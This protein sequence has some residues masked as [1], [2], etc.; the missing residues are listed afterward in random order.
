[1]K[2]GADTSEEYSLKL[3]DKDPLSSFRE[4]F[5]IPE[6]TVYL[7]GNSLGLL[8]KRAEES[9]MKVKEEWKELGI[10]GWT[11]GETPWFFMA[12]TLGE[13]AA[14][15]VGAEPK[16][17]V[18]TGTTTVNIH[19]LVSTLY[20]PDGKKDKIL[21][22][23]LNFPTDIYA[24]EGL[25]ELKGLDPEKKLK[26][27][28]SSDGDTLDED[29]IVDM[30]TDDIALIHLPS[31]LYRSGQLLDMQY[32]T[33]KAH[34]RDIVIGFDCSH[35]AGVIPHDLHDLGVDYAMWCGYKYLNGGPGCSAFLY[36]N[37]RHFEDE[38]KLKGWFGYEKEKQFDL[39]LDFVHEKSAGGWQISS[40]AILSSAPLLGS[41]EIIEEAGLKNIRDKSKEITNYF[42][43]LV[44]KVLKE[45]SYD[46]QVIS[47]RDAEHRSSHVAVKHENADV[48]SSLLRGKGFITDFRPP[49]VIRVA[50]SP[51][52][53]TYNEAW[54]T[55]MTIKDIIDDKEHERYEESDNKLVT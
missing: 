10:Q 34:E 32:L 14:D 42:I 16:E 19:S 25:L 49:N 38:P 22:D 9:V 6:G 40:P 55:V 21:A 46:F 8:S 33:E 37:E 44:D 5:Y 11:E 17:V 48:I 50:F 47:P 43:Y 12:E 41:L 15:M 31:V 27:V 13:M 20:K 23:E 18:A 30:M 52:Y 51:L 4:E 39:R 7:N 2:E 35:S 29:T 53:N 3:D 24:L 36:I 28:P 54:K 1:M 26:L 45:R